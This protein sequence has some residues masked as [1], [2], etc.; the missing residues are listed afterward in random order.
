MACGSGIGDAAFHRLEGLLRISLQPK[1]F[2]EIRT[3]SNRLV[4]LKS[5]D[6]R[7]ITYRGRAIKHS[8]YM[9]PRRFVLTQEVM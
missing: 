1:N 4:A 2:C 9:T 6:F 8:L 7:R 3:S 5:N